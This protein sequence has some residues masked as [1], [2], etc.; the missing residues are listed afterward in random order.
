MTNVVMPVEDSTGGGPDGPPRCLVVDDEPH[1]RRVLTRLMKADGFEC[2]EAENGLKAIES[3]AGSPAALVLTDLHM[4]ELDGIGLLR[5]CRRNYPDTAVVL[6]TAVSDVRTAVECLG[7]GAMD[8]LTKPFHVEE[9][10]ARVRQVLDKRRLVLENREYHERLEEKV[11]IQAR[12]I[13]DLFLASIQSLADSLE[14]RDTYTHG[15]SIR[16]S[17]YSALI[18]RELRLDEDAIRQVELGG[19]V[20]DVGKI[21]VREA[22]LNKQGPL[23]EEE[24]QHIMEHPMIGW[25]ILQPLLIEHPVSLNIVRNHHERWD[26][27]GLPDRLAADG[28][29]FEARIVAVADT[30][31]AMTSRRPYRPGLPIGA[32]LTEL[33]RCRGTQFDPRVVDAFVSVIGRGEVERIPESD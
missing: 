8:Y 30:F 31:D 26:G 23:T 2:E 24:Y 21:G 11:A 13:E 15:H 10:R 1:L 6:V 18:A 17:R 29:P 19:R 32:T 33:K 27:R 12:R 28:I 7:E 3:L 25:R 5:H 4:P 22:V 14:V 9:V 20:H 16:V